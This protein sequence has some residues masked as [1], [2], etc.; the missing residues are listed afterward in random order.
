V[1]P[2]TVTDLLPLCTFDPPG[3]PV[4]CAVSG[5]ADSSAL[6]ALAVAA[7]LR[8]TAVHVDHGARPES[9]GEADVVRAT[10]QRF[11]AAFET[12]R[13]RVAPGPNFEARARAARYAVLP[14]DALTGHTADD[15]AET[16]LIN[17]LRGAATGGLAAMRRSPQRPLLALRRAD[18]EAVCAALGIEVVH[19]RSNTDPRFV[20]NR[21]RAELV[22]LLNDIARRDVVPVLARQADLLR[23]DDDLL[24]ELAAAID[25]TDARAVSAAHPTLARRA[26]RRWLA[27]GHPPDLATVDRVLAVAAGTAKAC[28]VGGGRRVER[29]AQ[30]LRIVGPTTTPAI[31]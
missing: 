13:L 15:Q 5:G 29:T 23:D 16:V 10:A 17:L 4:A 25:P 8:V 26:I 19:D 7:G 3:T 2:A 6:L 9:A 20:R 14:T 21:V 31:G 22:P 30:R 11:G 28:D 27:T 1:W 12:H 18:T 24:D